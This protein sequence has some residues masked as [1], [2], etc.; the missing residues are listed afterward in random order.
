VVHLARFRACHLAEAAFPGILAIDSFVTSMTLR[1][2]R[3]N[4][5]CE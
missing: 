4:R 1:R 5:R 2:S 3:L